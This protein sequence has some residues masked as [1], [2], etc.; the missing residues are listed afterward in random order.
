[1][2]NASM[3]YVMRL[4]KAV[5]GEKVAVIVTKVRTMISGGPGHP[6]TPIGGR[7]ATATAATSDA[8]S[9]SERAVGTSQT[10]MRHG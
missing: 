1:M 7:N 4:W 5:E 2:S 3:R 6:R 9:S 8:I 10:N